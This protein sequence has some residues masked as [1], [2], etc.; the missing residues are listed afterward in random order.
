MQADN[1]KALLFVRIA[2]SS[3]V[4]L[5]FGPHN[6]STIAA[7]WPMLSRYCAGQVASLLFLDLIN[8]I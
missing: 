1:F 7:A 3:F 5:H 2:E 4:G 6:V 8:E